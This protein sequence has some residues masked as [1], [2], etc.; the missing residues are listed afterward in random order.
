MKRKILLPIVIFILAL[1]LPS[2]MPGGTQQ[3]QGWSGVVY[4]D[5]LL[6][7][8]SMDGQV[9]AVNPSTRNLEWSYTI[10][11]PS[12]SG[13]IM[14]C[15]QRAAPTAIY[16]T[17]VVDK[18]LVYIGVYNGKVIALNTLDRSQGLPFPQTRSEEW[19]FPNSDETIGEMVGNT[20]INKD[21][22]YVATTGLDGKKRV[23]VMYSLDRTFGD[24]NCPPKPL[25]EKCEKLWTTPSVEGDIIY[26]TT[27]NGYIYS[28]S[29]EDLALLPWTFK[30]D[31]GFVSSPIVYQD[32]IFVG[33]FDNNLYA[34]NIGD[35]EPIWKFPGGKWFWSTPVVKDGIVYAGC[36]DG[37]IYAVNAET[38][39]LEWEFDTGSPIVSSPIWDDDLLVVASQSGSIHVFDIN[40]KHA[41]KT[42]MPM[43]TMSISAVIRGSICVWEGI[44]YIRAQDN[45][46]YALNI[47]KGLISWK[48]PLSIK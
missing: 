22:V 26:V 38:G 42:I 21:D 13:G 2:C 12:T 23:C 29:T 31:A 25:G 43:R 4:S 37:K 44:I 5:G 46:L 10:S 24:L 34:I 48:L 39:Y 30:A 6:Y 18:D 3:A 15:G 41:D 32:T 7:V 45:C 33:A 1:T 19:S 20:V 35:S 16:S 8:G 17:P 47:D 40:S 28:L 11:T 14:S 27:Y 9:I 36:L